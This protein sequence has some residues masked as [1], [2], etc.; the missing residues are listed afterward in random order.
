[1]SPALNRLLAWGLQ[2]Y[3]AAE[4]DV[5]AVRAVT[6]VDRKAPACSGINGLAAG[7]EVSLCFG[8]ADACSDDGCTGWRAWAKATLLHEL[9]HVWISENVAQDVRDQFLSVSGL[10]TWESVDSLWG[11]RGVELAAEAMA[12]S[13]MDEPVTLNIEF[14]RRYSCAELARLYAILAGAP[15]VDPPC[16]DLGEPPPS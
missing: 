4:L 7:S 2:R 9:A 16:E 13:L 3:S 14:D 1:S 15:P 8:T 11:D 12:G 6:F 5:P 10:P